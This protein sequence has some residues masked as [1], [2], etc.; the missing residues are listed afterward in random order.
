MANNEN[1]HKHYKSLFSGA[2]SGMVSRSATAPLERLKI[3]RQVVKNLNRESMGYTFRNIIRT[4]GLRGLYKGN[5]VNMVRIAPYNAI[6]MASFYRYKELFGADENNP[7]RIIAASSCAGMTSVISCYPLDLIRSV[8]TIQKEKNKVYH[9]IRHTAT[10]IYR[11]RGIRGLY[12]GLTASMIGITPYVGV[13]LTVFE[14]LKHR[15][16]PKVSNPYFDVYNFGLGAVASTISVC[17]TYPTEVTRRR[18]QLSGI[19][20]RKQYNG[21]RDCVTQTWQTK[22]FFGFYTG[23]VP[24]VLRVVP[25][26]AIVMLV[27]ERMRK[28]LKF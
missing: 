23:F 8:L 11:E 2:I 9:G 21:I 13:N 17:T 24:C 26:M 3:M 10:S 28:W 27:N 1:G 7:S 6:Q 16:Q 15:F 22:G 5:G 18:L 25:C 12:S 4:E 19:L 20:G 14:L